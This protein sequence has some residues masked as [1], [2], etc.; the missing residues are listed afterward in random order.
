[1]QTR[2]LVGFALAAGGACAQFAPSSIEASAAGLTFRIP[3]GAK[4]QV[5]YIDGRGDDTGEVVPIYTQT[6]VDA[7][8]DARMQEAL[9]AVP[10]PEPMYTKAEVDALIDQRIKAALDPVL[11]A[12]LAASLHLTWHMPDMPHM[13]CH[14][15]I[16]PC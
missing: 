1:M 15:S 7:L 4:V 13:F 8:V 3:E 11:A 14:P 12:S 9:K 6:E 5:Q 16:W 10:K 2:I